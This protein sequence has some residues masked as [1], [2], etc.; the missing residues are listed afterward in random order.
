MDQGLVSSLIGQ[1]VDD[2]YGSRLGKVEGVYV[3]A[4]SAEPRWLLVRRGRMTGET[5]IVPCDDFVAGGGH[6]WLPI[7][8]DVIRAAPVPETTG[9][10]TARAERRLCDHYGVAAGER[11]S[12]LQGAAD[13]AI[14]SVLRAEAPVRA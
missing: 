14:T 3:D 7:E 10:L 4:S 13:Q 9:P 12:E 11:A 1:R 5:V 8:R 6:V 2:T